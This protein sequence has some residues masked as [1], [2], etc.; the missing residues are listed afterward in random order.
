[1]NL[2]EE[3]NIV[4][5]QPTI[6]LHNLDNNLDEYRLFFQEKLDKMDQVDVICFP[7]YWN[8]LRINSTSETAFS[9]SVRYLKSIA[10]KYTTWIVGGSQIVEEKEHF[11][12]RSLIINQRGEIIGKYD[13]QRLFGYELTQE[14]TPGKSLFTW[15]IGNFRAGICICNDLWNLNLVQE[16][17]SKEIDILFVPVLT[18]VPE[19][20][21]TNY[22]QHIWH[23]LALIRAKEGA[24]AIVVSDTAKSIFSDPYWSTGASCIADPSQNFTNQ[25]PRGKNML[26]KVNSGGRGV[27][28]KTINLQQLRAQ[29][30]YRKTVGLLV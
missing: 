21:L 12:N 25:E 23:N 4:V 5:L 2:S 6:T 8:G 18:V 1:M 19:E 11:Y 14:I 28:K 27:L 29:R 16:Q 24:M 26:K 13:K 10:Q 15:N 9:D 20:A 17:I 7:E 3:L 30:A 22:G